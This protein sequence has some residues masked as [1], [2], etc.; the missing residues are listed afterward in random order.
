MGFAG[1]SFCWGLVKKASGKARALG[2]W[3][4]SILPEISMMLDHGMDQ[5]LG[6]DIVV[7]SYAR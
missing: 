7:H 6:H 2:V 3:N 4:C 1:Y 5:I